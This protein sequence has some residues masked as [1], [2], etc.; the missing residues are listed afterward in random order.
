[1]TSGSPRPSGRDET[2]P[3]ADRKRMDAKRESCFGRAKVRLS[4]FP[5]TE[6]RAAI[7]DHWPS[8]KCPLLSSC[9]SGIWGPC[10][11]PRGWRTTSCADQK[12]RGNILAL[13]RASRL[14]TIRSTGQTLARGVDKMRHLMSVVATATVL[15]TIGL[16]RATNETFRYAVVKMVDLDK[17]TTNL[18]I[19]ASEFKTLQATVQTEAQ[20]FSR[21]LKAAADA[22]R[23]DETLRKQLF[24]SS[25]LAPRQLSVVGPWYD[26]EQQARQ[27]LINA[28][29]RSVLTAPQRRLAKADDKHEEAIAQATELVQ[30]ELCKLRR[31]F[32]SGDTAGPSTNKIELTAGQVLHRTTSGR[33]Q[34]KYHIAVPDKFDSQKPPP[35]LVVFS[36]GGDGNGM[37]SQVRASANKVGWM[38]LGCDTLKNGMKAEDELPIEEELMRDIRELVPHDPA[39]LY[40]GGFSGG[41]Q[42][43]YQMTHLF[44]DPCAGILAFGGWL[45]GGEEQKKSF[46]RGMA[47]AMV[48]GDGDKGASSWEESDKTILKR[49]GCKVTVFHFPGGHEVAPP[50]IIDTAIAWLDQETKAVANQPPERPR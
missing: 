10:F 5:C 48:N 4:R 37:M 30:A 13:V 45:G 44:T 36:P 31:G 16:A 9:T 43:A 38:V 29:S 22:W 33:M 47:V 19:S 2:R 24:P 14:P 12:D 32:V 11:A 3:T 18:M 17:S 26:S 34:T 35:L 25:D 1:M 28:T 39:R 49:R 42:R 20:F 27:A 50:A 6:V 15:L 21:A 23:K 8:N 40:Y 7:P 46:Q 41:A